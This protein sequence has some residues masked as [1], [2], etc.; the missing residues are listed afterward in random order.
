MCIRD[1]GSAQTISVDAPYIRDRHTA[2]ALRNR[3]FDDAERAWIVDV[4]TDLSMLA[5]DVGD[6][7]TVEHD[8]LPGGTLFGT[9]TRQS[10]DILTGRIDYTVRCADA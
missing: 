3:L 5:L 8:A 6:R 4:A 2:I 10:V 1:S 9:I 7:V